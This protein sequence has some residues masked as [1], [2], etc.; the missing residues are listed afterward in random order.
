MSA[1]EEL[2]LTDAAEMVLRSRDL[3]DIA[4]RS[5]LVVWSALT[6]LP[7][8]DALAYAQQLWDHHAITRAAVP[9]F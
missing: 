9:P 1:P 5:A 2:N 4:H 3:G 8:D 6:G 7:K